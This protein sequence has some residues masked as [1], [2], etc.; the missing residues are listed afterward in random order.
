[1]SHSVLV[2]SMMFS[3]RS[4][5]R[6]RQAGDLTA[7]WTSGLPADQTRVAMW[8]HTSA[9]D[10]EPGLR[11]ARVGPGD[12]RAR[13]MRL[14]VRGREPP[15]GPPRLNSTRAVSMALVHRRRPAARSG[16]CRRAG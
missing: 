1:M 13:D 7:L 2:I 5:Y 12:F 9:R 15:S 11:T 6:G 4:I 14:I 8:L 16:R 3:I 10:A